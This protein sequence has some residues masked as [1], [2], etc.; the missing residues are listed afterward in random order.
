MSNFNHIEITDEILIA[1]IANELDVDFAAYVEDWIK[2]DPVNENRYKELVKTWEFVGTIQPSPVVVNVDNAW[3]SVLNKISPEEKII[4]LKRN[5]R[6]TILWSSAASI[7]I[8]IG[9]FSILKFTGV[10]NLNVNRFANETGLRDELSD[11]SVIQLNANSSLAYLSEFEEDE[12][13][14]ALKGEAFFEITKDEKRPFIV[15]L[16]D[17]LYVKVLGTSFNVKSIDGDSITEV[18][19]KTGKVEFGNLENKLLLV[20]GEKGIFNRTTNQFYKETKASTGLSELYWISGEVK[21][22]GV[23]LNEVIEVLNTIFDADSKVVLACPD[24]QNLRIVSSLK[25]D[26]S[27]EQILK[28]IAEIHG[29]II[30][31]GSVGSKQVFT[32]KCDG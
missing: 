24:R 11:G 29:F 23:P 30:E 5:W 15:D 27:I 14:V 25:K 22:D 13:K 28:V 18:Y 4:P 32:L 9:I 31:K 20:P 21:F 12:R 6:K 19:V 8:L 16:Q 26:Q 7:L 3:Q 2:K 1:F 10:E 17:E